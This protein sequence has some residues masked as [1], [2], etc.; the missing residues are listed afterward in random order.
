MSELEMRRE[1]VEGLQQQLDEIMVAIG[2]ACMP[3][4]IVPRI[5]TL[6]AELAEL[7]SLDEAAGRELGAQV[8]RV[9]ELEGEVERL[10]GERD[11]AMERA[12]VSRKARNAELSLTISAEDRC[13]ELNA[14][15]VHQA[16]DLAAKDAFSRALRE[17]LRVIVNLAGHPHIMSGGRVDE[18]R[19]RHVHASA[20]DPITHAR[21]LLTAE[22]G[23]AEQK[24][25]AKDCTCHFCASF[26]K[27]NACPIHPTE[28]PNCSGADL[29]RAC[30][31]QLLRMVRDEDYDPEPPVCGHPS[32]DIETSDEGTSYCRGCERDARAETCERCGGSGFLPDPYPVEYVPGNKKEP[33]PTCTEKGVDR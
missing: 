32:S 8:A 7:K 15:V 21:A 30:A 19:I 17:A 24:E 25:H 2:E 29:C 13:S 10:R 14:T 27:A 18:Y 12:E 33:C 1:Q 5:T 16:E 22:S 23:V 26:R 6:R 3:S 4:D 31:E 20:P 11:E 9:R 28:P